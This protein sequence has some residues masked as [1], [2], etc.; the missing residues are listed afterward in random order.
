MRSLFLSL[1]VAGGGLGLLLGAFTIRPPDVTDRR[2]PV[3][4]G[5]AAALVLLV[6]FLYATLAVDWPRLDLTQHL[7]F[8]VLGGLAAFI[9][10]RLYLAF[11]ESQLRKANWNQPSPSGWSC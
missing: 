6:T 7:I 8:T 4:L 1:H 9:L 5:Y 11:R 3:R 2:L 10:L